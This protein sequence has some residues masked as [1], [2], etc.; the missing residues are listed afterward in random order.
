MMIRSLCMT[1]R[2]VR[3]PAMLCKKHTSLQ[4]CFQGSMAIY[5][6][7]IMLT[8]CFVLEPP[9]ICCVIL[10]RVPIT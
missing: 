9:C 5:Q 6:A 2:A 1:N 3:Y 4:G 7:S 10:L 8:V